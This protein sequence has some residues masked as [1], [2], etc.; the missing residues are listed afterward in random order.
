MRILMINVVCGIRSTGRICTDLAK[1]LQAK[2][3]TVQIAYGRETVPDAAKPYA[4]RIGADTDVKLHAVR[5]RLTDGCGYGSKRATERFLDWVRDYDPDVIHLH[6]LHGY[7][8]NLPLLFGYLRTCGKKILWTLHDCWA[9]TGHSAFCDAVS[10][11][12]WADGCHD[13]PKVREYPASLI[14]RSAQN[15]QDRKRMFTGIPNLRIVTP[16]EW[17][18]KVAQRSFFGAYPITVIRSGIDL[19]KFYPSRNDTKESFRI[20]KQLLLFAAADWTEDVLQSALPFLQRLNDD[21]T[22]LFYGLSETQRQQLPC[23]A[24]AMEPTASSKELEMLCHA[25]DG[26]VLFG[27]PEAMLSDA[28]RDAKTPIVATPED[29]NKLPLCA[30]DNA[31]AAGFWA[32]RKEFGLLGKRVLLGV[33][34]DWG[35][36]IKGLPDLMKLRGALDD[37]TEMIVVGV[38]ERERDALPPNMIGLLRTDRVET[39]RRLYAAVDWYVNPTYVDTLSMTNLEAVACGTPV[40]TYRTG[41]SPESAM[42]TGPV[43]PKGDIDAMTRFFCKTEYAS[44]SV[45]PASVDGTRATEAYLRLYEQ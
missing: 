42:G 31:D 26:A 14:D 30:P 1:A 15:W 10:C 45:P 25:A 3:H 24:R 40:A 19:R 22:A 16:S 35:G 11:E 36:T 8:L 28:L 23:N 5:A 43:F 20:P 9:F 41:G 21:R 32:T 7:Y 18:A 44:A 12:R 37:R 17:M 38:S 6:N 33:Q 4:V 2:G 34:S 13:C 27:T 29:A 39:L